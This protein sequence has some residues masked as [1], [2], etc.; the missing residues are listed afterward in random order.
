MVYWLN[1]ALRRSHMCI[2]MS[3]VYRLIIVWLVFKIYVY[4]YKRLQTCM[5]FYEFYGSWLVLAISY[6][7]LSTIN[8]LKINNI[9]PS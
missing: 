2:E 3:L 8:K 6:L 5:I 7:K 9:L 4:V 1:I